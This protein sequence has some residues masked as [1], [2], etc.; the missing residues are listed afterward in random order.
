[1]PAFAR[2]LQELL[3]RVEPVGLVV[4]YPVVNA[5]EGTACTM[6]KQVMT[7]FSQAAP[8]V[9]RSSARLR[10]AAR[11]RH[12]VRSPIHPPFAA[13]V[14]L[15][16][17]PWDEQYST[18]QAEVFRASLRIPYADRRHVVDQVAATFILQVRSH[19]LAAIAGLGSALHWC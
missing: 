18:A 8:Q 13:Q 3:R 7:E 5:V 10:H 6:V 9:C 4:G 11:V 2:S 17:L 15:P 16:V 19:A 1:M 12:R 14:A